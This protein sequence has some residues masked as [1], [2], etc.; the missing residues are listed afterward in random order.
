MLILSAKLEDECVILIIDAALAMVNL[1]K[2]W[3]IVLFHYDVYACCWY[4]SIVGT[5][6]FSSL[7]Y[8]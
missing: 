6:V 5:K 2:P 7:G 4:G 8:H 3:T 1:V